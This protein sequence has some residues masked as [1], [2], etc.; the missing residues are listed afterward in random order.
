MPKRRFNPWLYRYYERFTVKDGAESLDSVAFLVGSPDISGGTYVI[1]EHALWLKRH[2]VDVAIV[3]MYPKDV[4]AENWHPALSELEFLSIPEAAPRKFDVAVATWWLTVYQLPQLRFRHP[5]YFV[6]SMEARHEADYDK[7]VTA[8]AELTYSYGIPTITIATWMQAYLAFQH[9]AP[10]FI[11]RNGIDKS[12]YSLDGPV[13]SPRPDEGLRVLIEGPVNQDAPRKGIDE[14]IEVARRAGCEEVWLLTSSDVSE[15]PGCDVVFS[16]IPAE[17]TG[18]VY[19]S[20][21]LLLKQT[22]AEG[23]YGPPLEMFH[24]GGTVVTNDVAGHEEYIV[25]G[26]NG[27]VVETDNSDAA[28]QALKRIREDRSLLDRLTTGA[29]ETATD[30]HDWESSSREFGRILSTIAR[31]PA[32]DLA[33]LC[34]EL[35]GAFPLDQLVQSQAREG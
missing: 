6:Q 5:V 31:Q 10:S 9:D 29:Q 32:E 15:Y 1:F 17:K 2:G 19:R 16:R 21:H 23:M 33:P 20:C 25:D 3:S 35:M 13:A 24:C 26:V 27:L 8:L 12:R 11:A 4:A 7:S 34:R 30:W 28:V 14:S 18:E 22:N